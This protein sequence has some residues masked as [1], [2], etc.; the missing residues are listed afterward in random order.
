MRIG[1]KIGVVGFVASGVLTGYL[2][3]KS[4]PVED[5][6]TTDATVHSEEVQQMGR[7]L[8]AAARPTAVFERLR[9]AGHWLR[10][11]SAHANE[12]VT[13]AANA[14]ARKPRRGLGTARAE[15]P[16]KTT[17]PSTDSP[18]SEAS[19][20]QPKLPSAEPNPSLAHKPEHTIRSSQTVEPEQSIG[21]AADS[22]SDA[23]SP[24]PP[25]VHPAEPY[26]SLKFR[27]HRFLV[28]Q[29]VLAAG[30]IDES[31]LSAE[32]DHGRYIV[33]LDLSV[34]NQ[35]EERG[36]RFSHEDLRLQGSKGL[37]YTPVRPRDGLSADL[38]AGQ[39]ARGGVAFAV[40][41][42]SAPA[43]L[44]YR[45]GPD[46]FVPLP[47]NFFSRS[48]NPSVSQAAPAGPTSNGQGEFHTG[49]GS[50]GSRSVQRG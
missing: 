48:Y 50:A 43:R 38:G 40:Y 1:L 7:E 41:N 21:P 13:R 37:V 16:T 8:G 42:D 49:L 11:R 39:T 26:P 36:C 17:A 5:T 45:T 47:E 20:S 44:L 35:D 29:Q 31:V 24:I 46:S 2:E 32:E 14:N 28:G 25:S 23:G 9:G 10:I 4:E 30:V 34:T 22:A 6:Q 27:L 18:P 3:W 12:A 15:T 33:Y 19:P